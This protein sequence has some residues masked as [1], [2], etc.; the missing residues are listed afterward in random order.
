VAELR[1]EILFKQPESNFLGDC[2]ICC[3]PHSIDQKKSTM[4]SCCSKV[5]CNGCTCTN[6]MR[7]RQQ[8]LKST[9]PFCRQLPPKTTQEEEE[10]VMK[11][12]E[13]NDPVAMCQM[14]TYRYDEG[15]YDGAFEYLTKAAEL[16]DLTAHYVLSVMYQ[17][18]RGVEKDKKKQMH[19]L[20]QAAIGGHPRARHNIG[21]VE[22]ENGRLERA[23]KHWIIAAK[24]GNDRS[25]GTL[26]D[27]YSTGN[28]SKEDF[29][30]ALRGH[31]AA[32]DAT[33]SSQRD[34]AE[35]ALQ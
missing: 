9:C 13:V 33:K 28:V 24:L 10:M 4:M 20:E 21:G 34:E 11:R 29:A 30:A 35:V 32:V 18:G 12:I 1:D 5:I 26:R 27:L 14:G 17:D 2:P 31:Q 7:E 23:V 3:L 6:I 19:H 15:D 25:L 22:W 8:S 16:G